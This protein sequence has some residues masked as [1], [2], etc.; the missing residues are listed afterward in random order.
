[1]EIADEQSDAEPE[2][3]SEVEIADEQSDAG[4]DA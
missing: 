4:P 3:E 2:A 1:V